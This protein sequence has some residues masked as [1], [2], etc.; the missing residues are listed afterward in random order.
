MWDPSYE[1]I[2]HTADWAIRV[3]G[4]D[5][6]DLFA[7]AARGMFSLVADLAAVA[8][9]RELE[10]DLRAI[11]TETLLID[12]LNELLYLAEQKRIIFSSFQIL[13]LDEPEPGHADGAAHLRARVAGG[14]VPALRKTI[15][16]AT[17]N[18]LAIARDAAGVTTEIVFDV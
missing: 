12:W 18:S 6:R 14:P 2:E 8:P 4:R 5:L 7:A 17:F 15:K 9:G 3:R 16:A 11:D 1:E 13:Q 10:L